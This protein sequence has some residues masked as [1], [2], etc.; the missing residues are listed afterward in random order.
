[1]ISSTLK[2]NIVANYLGRAYSVASIYIFTPF[3]IRILGIESYGVIS[4]YAILLLLTAVA[5]VGLSATFSREAAGARKGAELGRLLCSIEATLALSSIGLSLFPFV[6]SGVIAGNWLHHSKLLD[7]ETVSVSVKIMSVMVPMQLLITL[8]SSGLMGL[9]KQVL[10]NKLQFI[11]TSFRSGLVII[12]IYFIPSLEVFFIWQLVAMAIYAATLRGAALRSMSLRSWFVSAP[13]LQIL[14]SV[15]NFSLGAFAIAVISNVANQLDKIY[16]STRFDVDKFGY[17]T[18]ASSLTQIANAAVAPIIAG[19]FPILVGLAVNGDS[20]RASRTFERFSLIVAFVASLAATFLFFFA[21]DVIGMW[22]GARVPLYVGSIVKWQ[23]LGWLFF[24][25]QLM[26]TY[27]SLAHSR[28]RPVVLAGIGLLAVGAPLLI[29]LSSTYGIVGAAVPW[30]IA[31]VAAFLLLLLLVVAPLYSG[32]ASA[33]LWRFT[34]LPAAGAAAIA[35]LAKALAAL[36]GLGPLGSCVIGGAVVTAVAGGCAFV[37]V[38]VFNLLDG[39]IEGN[40]APSC[41]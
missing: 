39:G 24:A 9:Q 28:T 34:A 25:L 26:P 33:W 36:S 16:V 6:L 21:D 18:A 8:Y 2:R 11:Y 22:L 10:L 27:L 35:A 32:S 31:N 3:Y 4:F 5:D 30:F 12:V 20:V 41:A 1:M 7:P 38:R 29:L 23:A 37:A 15:A 19:L 13:S 14:K 17:F 40:D